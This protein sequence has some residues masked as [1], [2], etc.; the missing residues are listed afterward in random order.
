MRPEFDG[1]RIAPVIPESWKGFTV[2][3]TF[4]GVT[5]R[6]I[7]RREGTGNSVKL[8]V[9]GKPIDGAVILASAASGKE[10]KVEA[11]LG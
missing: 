4:R 7:V 11:V 8:T 5:Y 9:D 6:I 2:S 3:R 1:L 10:V